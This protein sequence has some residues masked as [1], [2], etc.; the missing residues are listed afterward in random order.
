MTSQEISA[1]KFR[2]REPVAPRGRQ[3]TKPPS[4]KNGP[5]QR[6]DKWLPGIPEWEEM[7][8]SRRNLSHSEG[9]QEC[10][11]LSAQY[12]KMW[13]KMASFLI[14]LDQ[15]LQ[16]LTAKKVPFVLTGAHGIS[17]WT[18]RPRATHDVDILVKGGRNY[19]RAVSVIKALYPDLESRRFAGL[20][21]F[22]RPGE[23]ESL[24]EV[25]Y[26]HR[27]DNAETLRTAI[28]VEERSQKYRI[29]SLEAAL[30]NKYGAMLTPTRDT[31]KR[32]QDAVDF[33]A[34]VKHSLDEGRQP[35]DLAIVESL[36]EMVWPGGGG[37]EILRLIEEV[38]SGKVPTLLF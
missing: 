23:K 19:A 9:V 4:T 33:A 10:A 3:A 25:I 24:I 36:G 6:A 8:A 38:K 12:R 26:P 18:G 34:M 32:G 30:A 5:A 27:P 29:P 20:T 31:I 21:A 16:A 13:S 22:F 15:I 7:K 37:K 2:T 35:I 1:M 14:D 11:Y 28:W 17:S